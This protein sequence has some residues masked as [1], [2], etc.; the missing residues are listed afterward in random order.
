MRGKVRKKLAVLCA[1]LLSVVTLL[2]NQIPGGVKAAAPTLQVSYQS[3]SEGNGIVEIKTTAEAQWTSA[4][5]ANQ[6]AVSVRVKA[7]SGYQIDWTHIYLRVNGQDILTDAIRTSLA[8]DAGYSLQDDVSYALENVEFRSDSGQPPQG[9]TSTGVEIALEGDACSPM[10]YANMKAADPTFELYVSVDG[11]ASYKTL[12]SLLAESPSVV[13]ESGSRY[14]F[15]NTVTSIKAY[16]TLNTTKF[17]MDGFPSAIGTSAATATT[18]TGEQH[19]QID[20]Q[21][22]TIVWAYDEIRF[23]ADAYLEHGK[24]Q[25]IAIEGID[26]F[27]TIPF[28]NNP[29]NA[30][31]GHI[32]VPTGKKVTIKLIPDYG[33]QVAGLTLNGG[34]TLTPD[35]ANMSTFTF[36]MGQNNVHLKGMFKKVEDTV[37]TTSK[38]VDAATIQNG[39]NAVASG[40]LRLSVADNS[41]Y[42]TAKAEALVENAE[43]AQAIDLTLDQ[44]VSK[45]NGSNWEK[46]ITEFDKPITLSLALDDYDSGYDYTVVRNHNGTLTELDTE[47]SNG[48]VSFDTNQ[49]STYVIVKVKK[50]KAPEAE[51]DNPKA[52]TTEATTQAPA[53]NKDKS[54]E[55]GDATMPIV[56]VFGCA[57][58]AIGCVML[59]RKRRE[60]NI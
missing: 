22:V 4:T 59:A 1:L 58:S 50:Q 55:T 31:G 20:K 56:L 6:N 51:V 7:N 47:V 52:P 25:V 49:F 53:A 46:N 10:T 30:E 32:A 60:E 48:T 35:D 21:A 12:G 27:N 14:S 11:G 5:N 2:G 18:I 36:V 16:V 8:S 45:G 42:D 34:E 29:G 57:V 19:I 17:M 44:V 9:P 26:D 54:P 15:S 24:A 43:S 41:S 23:G 37:A 39:A 40:N 28:A 33:Y 13:S 3:G 38:S